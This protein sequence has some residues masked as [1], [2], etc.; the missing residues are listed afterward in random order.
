[1]KM[2]TLS[3]ICLLCAIGW[4]GTLG[5]IDI[6]AAG[7]AEPSAEKPPARPGPS[8]EDVQRADTLF[9]RARLLRAQGKLD[10][11]CPLF[12]ESN[13][14]DPSP[15]THYNLADC[16]EAQGK[17]GTAWRDLNAAYGAAIAANDKELAATI[18][19]RRSLLLPKLL[20]LTV[21]VPGRLATQAGLRVEYDGIR[22]DTGLPT[23]FFVVNPGPHQVKAS[24]P[25]YEPFEQTVRLDTLNPKATIDVKLERVKVP[26]TTRP[27]WG[28]WLCVGGGATT[29]AGVLAASFGFPNKN[30]GL[31]FAGIAIGAAGLATL[32]VGIALLAQGPALVPKPL[33]V[34][35]VP[36]A[37]VLF[38]VAPLVDPTG[39]GVLIRMAY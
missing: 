4:T 7:A 33:R 6:P 21:R 25:D 11:A 15:G 24:A 39:G 19:K 34:T 3:R 28:A 10:E 5:V 1:M 18:S 12:E 23:R 20:I 27:D 8:K 22:M 36:S 30:D 14:L 17:T 37:G 16:H 29:L 13:N 2:G 35:S 31:G 26:D 32:G 9:R 38:G